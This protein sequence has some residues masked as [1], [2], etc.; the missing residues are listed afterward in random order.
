MRTLYLVRHAKSSWNNSL[1][2]DFDRPLN[3]RGMESAPLM[4]QRLK[5]KKILPGMMVSSPA[6][7]AIT[8]AG[9]FA[10]VLGYP[11]EAIVQ[12]MAIYTGGTGDLLQIVRAFPDSSASAM[13]FGHN[14]VITEFSN[15]LTGEDLDNMVT[16][17]IVRIDMA[18]NWSDA[19]DRT[20][21]R[22]WYDYPKK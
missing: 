17:G 1:I 7:R 21:S 9:I 18:G 16:C 3:D 8:T 20:G 13:L 22:I 5:E 19:G 12:D 6:N 10:G 15:L 2:S 11:V 14:P 4:A